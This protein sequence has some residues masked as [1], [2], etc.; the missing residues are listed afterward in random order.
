MVYFGQVMGVL[1]RAMGVLI[2]HFYFGQVMG[3]LIRP[4]GV[5][6]RLMGVLIRSIRL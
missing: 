5:L 1:I 3:V 4:V 6:I 2:R